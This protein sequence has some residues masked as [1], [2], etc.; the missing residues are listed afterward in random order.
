MFFSNETSRRVWLWLLVLVI[1]FAI[2]IVAAASTLS[3]W[4]VLGKL[5]QLNLVSALKAPE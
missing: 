4:L 2:A 5:N 1:A 3:A